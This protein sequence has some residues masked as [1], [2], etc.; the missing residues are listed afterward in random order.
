MHHNHPIQGGLTVCEASIAAGLSCYPSAAGD[1]I[2]VWC[3]LY[4]MRMF[5]VYSLCLS[6]RL[7]KKIP[8]A[9][10]A[11]Q[12]SRF[13]CRNSWRENRYRRRW[14][15]SYERG[16]SFFISSLCFSQQPSGYH[17]NLPITVTTSAFLW[18]FTYI[19]KLH[20]FE[21]AHGKSQSCT[22]AVW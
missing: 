4:L 19:S 13:C 14:P 3:S 8:K 12:D 17:E 9:M 22:K 16:I 11:S 20:N 15:S 10:A 1:V 7:T 6:H 5:L 2:W 21:N 18:L